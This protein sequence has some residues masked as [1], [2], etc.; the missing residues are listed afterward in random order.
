MRRKAL[1]NSLP[2]GCPKSPHDGVGTIG[3]FQAMLKRYRSMASFFG[4]ML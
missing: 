4:A 2:F 1:A 3:T